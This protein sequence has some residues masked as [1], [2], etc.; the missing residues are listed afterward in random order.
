MIWKHIRAYIQMSLL[1]HPHHSFPSVGNGPNT[2]SESMVSNT[3]L[4]EFFC[5]HRVPG[6]ELIEFLSAY[7]LCDKANSPSFSQNSPSL[8][9]NSARLT[10]FSSP[11]QYYSRNSIPPVS[12]SV[13]NTTKASTMASGCAVD[14]NVIAT[15]TS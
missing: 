6:R 5:P 13:D 9:Q 2:V 12:Y 14:C 8:P 4:S 7:Y 15:Q 1:W 10:E 11:R 3:K